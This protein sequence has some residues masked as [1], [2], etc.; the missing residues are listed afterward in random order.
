MRSETCI[1]V[2][3]FRA[4]NCMQ[5]G[6]VKPIEQKGKRTRQQ[7]RSITQWLGTGLKIT[8]TLISDKTDGSAASRV[9][10][11][12]ESTCASSLNI[13]ARFQNRIESV[14]DNFVA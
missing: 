1:A 11:Q 10:H 3:A 13:I 8:L 5:N 7:T 12:S 9:C 4:L 14:S 2:G 6:V